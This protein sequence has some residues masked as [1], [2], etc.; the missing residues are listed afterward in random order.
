MTSFRSRRF[1]MIAQRG[2]YIQ[3]AGFGSSFKSVL[4]QLTYIWSK[5]P[6]FNKCAWIAEDRF[7]HKK[8]KLNSRNKFWYE[9]K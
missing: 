4:D 7:R 2:K 8:F 1:V 5:L 3:K 6:Q 9:V